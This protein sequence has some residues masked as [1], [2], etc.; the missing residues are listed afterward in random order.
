MMNLC[1]FSKG[2]FAPLLLSLLVTTCSSPK[3]TDLHWLSGTW[4]NQ[5]SPEKEIFEHW[6][7]QADN[8]LSG[9]SYLL[10][11]SKEVLLETV[12]IEEKD[13][14]IFYTP[15]V[16][17]Q[18]DGAAIPFR[19]TK[20]SATSSTFEN[21]EHDFPQVIRY[22]KVGRDSLVATISGE[23]DGAFQERFFRMRRLG[24]FKVNIPG[25]ELEAE[26]VWR[27]IRDIE[28]FEQYNYTLSLPEGSL[29]EALKVKSRKKQLSDSDFEA[30]S[31][32]MRDSIYQIEDYQKG[33]QK[34]ILQA[35]KVDQMLQVLAAQDYQWGFKVYPIYQINLTL[36]GPGG[37]FDPSLGAIE[38][39]TTTDGQFKGYSDPVNTLIHE[40]VHLGI[41]AS[42]IDEYEVPHPMKERIVDKMVDTFFQDQLPNY[43]VQEMGENRIDRYL[44]TQKDFQQLDKWVVDILKNEP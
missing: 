1:D 22:E 6:K 30:L 21:P 17:N 24:R 3:V 44:K 19:M 10:K 25:P 37:S 41:Q 14:S 38:I 34:I 13:R 16:A 42:I 40:V 26:R 12:S 32:F 15:Q 4:I 20:Q 43:R 35:S 8:R 7:I 27:H 5:A 28:F 18:N 23:R 29:I 33:Y 36:Y 9:K 2:A 11:G 31:A 39:F